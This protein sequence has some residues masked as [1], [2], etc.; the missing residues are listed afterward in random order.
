MQVAFIESYSDI[1]VSHL[2]LQSMKHLHNMN[3]IIAKIIST[4]IKLSS[5]TYI[6]IVI[7]LKNYYTIFIATKNAWNKIHE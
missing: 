6:C 3:I 5:F 4:F 2:I 7:Y 1:F